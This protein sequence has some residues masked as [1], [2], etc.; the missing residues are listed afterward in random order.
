MT[1]VS[2]E[3]AELYGRCCPGG[4]AHA[5][6][7]GVDLEYFRPRPGGL[8]R[9][10]VFVGALDYRPNV[11]GIGRFCEEVWPEVRR[12]DPGATIR[13]VGRRPAPE[14]RRL[15]RRPGVEVVGQVPD[16]RPYL[17]QA[18]VVVV[19]LWIAPGVQNKVLEAL[20]MAKP[21]VASP[22]A[23]A[24]LR[25]RAGAHL[26]SASTAVEWADAVTRLASDPDLRRRIGAEGRRYV[27]ANHRWDHCLGAFAPLLGL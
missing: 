22:G 24:G 11:A 7:N 1:L 2:D 20:A 13:L 19:P 16:V 3:E 26:L 10:C 23:L 18:A 14:V 9:G 15:A 17:E 6:T 25:A 4:A 21:V 12:R 5:I 8:E 27:E